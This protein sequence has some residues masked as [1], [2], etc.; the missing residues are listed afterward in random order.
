MET[1]RH[2]MLTAEFFKYT[3][4]KSNKTYHNNHQ[5]NKNKQKVTDDYYDIQEEDKL[6]WAFYIIQYGYENYS[7]LKK[8]FSTEKQLKFSIIETLKSEKQTLKQ[9][10]IRISLLIE[11]LGTSHIISLPTLIGLCCAFKKN[12]CVFRNKI[13]A[14][15]EFDTSK[16]NYSIVDCNSQKLL[17]KTMDDSIL[18][19]KYVIVSSL[20]KPLKGVSSFTKV[21]P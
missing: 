20:D 14:R 1:L 19:S 21:I 2:H 11:D 7:Q 9:F 5:I 4:F 6:F 12:I 16:L 15:Y 18:E 17:R 13:M 3:T 8:T 10:K